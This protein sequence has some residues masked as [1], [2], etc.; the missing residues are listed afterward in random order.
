MHLPL[1]LFLFS[2][3]ALAFAYTS[4]YVFGMEPCIFCL[5]QRIPFFAILPLSFISIFAKNKL[6]LALVTLCGIILLIGAA[7]AFYHVGIE[8]GRFVLESECGFEDTL[9]STLEEATMQILGKAYVPCNK[10]QF[11]F[12]GISMAGWNFLLSA[13][14]GLITLIMVFRAVR[15]IYYTRKSEKYLKEKEERK[16][17]EKN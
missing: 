15:T 8:Q 17:D 12:L 11:I 2:A 1:F 5:Y 14:V 13:S 9:P 4:Q 7:I 3:G 6:K 10:P 16:E